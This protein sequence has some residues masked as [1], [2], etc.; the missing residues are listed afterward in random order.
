M[1]KFR[2]RQSLRQ[3]R[4]SI[5]KR[6]RLYAAKALLRH[7]Q[8]L[9]RRYCR[10][11]LYFPLKEEIDPTLMMQAALK[12][13]KKVYL[14]VLQGKRLLFASIE[15]ALWKKNRFGIPEPRGRKASPKNMDIVFVPLLG[16]DE[17]RNRLGMG[18][19]FYDRTFAFLKHRESWRSPRL[20]GLAFD[21]QKVDRL[22]VDPWDMQLD[23]VITPSGYR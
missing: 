8:P 23:A 16:F 14:P 9:L 21:E 22:P 10:I 18:G 13:N 2:I 3:K 4:R 11:G 7:A 1:N 12:K 19:G 20:I 15:T 6:R 17:Y 5:P